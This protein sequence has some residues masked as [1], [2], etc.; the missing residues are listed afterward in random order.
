MTLLCTCHVLHNVPGTPTRPTLIEKACYVQHA[1]KKCRQHAV[2]PVTHCRCNVKC[3]LMVC[4]WGLRIKHA[5]L[6]LKACCITKPLLLCSICVPAL[7]LRQETAELAH[8]HRHA[9]KTL[10]VTEPQHMRSTAS[11]Q[12]KHSLSCFC[13]LL[14]PFPELVLTQDHILSLRKQSGFS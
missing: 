7:P 2:L 1:Y 4:E 10:P 6:V 14:L 13:K 9:C 5:S 8:Q 12:A 3:Y 11:I